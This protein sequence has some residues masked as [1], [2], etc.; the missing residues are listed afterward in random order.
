MSEPVFTLEQIKAAFRTQFRGRGEVYFPY[1][2]EYRA[3]EVY[4]SEWTEFAETLVKQN[5]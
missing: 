3:E 2:D 1:T 4:Q 5:G